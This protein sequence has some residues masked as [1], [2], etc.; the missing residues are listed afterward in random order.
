M[1][2]YKLLCAFFLQISTENNNFIFIGHYHHLMKKVKGKG[3]E[4]AVQEVEGPRFWDDRHMK[5]A[6]TP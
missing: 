1:P 2:L 4:I 6:L 5:A 3:K